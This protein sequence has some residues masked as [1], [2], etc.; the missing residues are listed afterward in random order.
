MSFQ[1]QELRDTSE[2]R[3]DMYRDLLNLLQRVLDL[4][5]GQQVIFPQDNNPK[6]TAEISGCGIT[7]L[8][9]CLWDNSVTGP[10]RAQI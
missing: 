2:S 9:Q 1:W 5:L 4:R 10:A 6:D 3:E 7:L 8:K